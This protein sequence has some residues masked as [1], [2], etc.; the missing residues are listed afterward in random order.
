M[1]LI[2][3]NIMTNKIEYKN[4]GSFITVE[5][6]KFPMMMTEIMI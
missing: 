3:E 4:I 1:N 6:V 5:T 2:S